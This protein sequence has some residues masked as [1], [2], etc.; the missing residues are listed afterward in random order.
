MHLF[1]KN[2]LGCYLGDFLQA[3]LATLIMEQSLLCTDLEKKILDTPHF[4]LYL[5][6][7][8]CGHSVGFGPR[9]SKSK[10]CIIAGNG[11]LKRQKVKGKKVLESRCVTMYRRTRVDTER[12]GDSES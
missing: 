3:R 7:I 1:L 4:F 12:N 5:D 6:L 9:I 11:A 2:A 8:P 10:M